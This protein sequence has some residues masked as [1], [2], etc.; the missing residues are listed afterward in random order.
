M[1]QITDANADAIDE[2]RQ[3]EEDF[4]DGAA[5]IQQ[6]DTFHFM[7]D[8]GDGPDAFMPCHYDHRFTKKK[9]YAA[10]QYSERRSK[11][12]PP[13]QQSQSITVTQHLDTESFVDSHLGPDGTETRDSDADF[14]ILQ[15]DQDYRGDIR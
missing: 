13:M 7:L 2:A 1:D 8:G 15:R 4:A 6:G 11:P 9:K 3:K 14:E 5:R 10:K 12:P